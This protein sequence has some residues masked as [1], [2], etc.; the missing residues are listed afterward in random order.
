[1]IDY[2]PREEN[3]QLFTLALGY[4]SGCFGLFYGEQPSL[5]YEEALWRMAETDPRPERRS[6]A[7]RTYCGI[8][9]S[10][11]ALGRVNA[12]WND[13]ALAKRYRLSEGDVTD[14]PT[15]MRCVSGTGAG[16]SPPVN[17]VGLQSGSVGAI[18][19][20]RTRGIAGCCCTRFGFPGFIGG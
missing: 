18:R 1:M 3:H 19:L 12:L 5:A 14:W 13:E 4:A 7:V 11:E 17:E 8:A 16:R 9:R 10:P 15:P 20:Y 6:L 2:L